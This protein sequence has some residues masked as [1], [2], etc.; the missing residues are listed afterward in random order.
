[1]DT[2]EKI[3]FKFVFNLLLM[4]DFEICISFMLLSFKICVTSL[5]Q[6]KCPLY[7]INN[8]YVQDFFNKIFVIS[9]IKRE[10]CCYLLLP[11]YLL[12]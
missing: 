11:G 1:M 7:S 12:P 2:F 6:L 10:V 9:E 5:T 8:W 4:S 3:I